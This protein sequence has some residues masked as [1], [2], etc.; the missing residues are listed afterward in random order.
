MT[1]YQEL[2]LNQS[3]SKNYIASFIKPKDKFVHTLIFIF[4]VLL[5]L[6]FCTAVVMGLGIVFGAENSI[7]GLV[8]LL[9]ILTFRFTDL[10]IHATHSVYG[11]SFIFLIFALGPKAA[12]LAPAGCDWLINFVC[13][14]LIVVVGCHNVNWYNHS[15]L[16]L[17]YLLL[18]GYDV[19]GVS[20]I[21]RL[22]CL[23]FGAILTSLVLYRNRRKTE[24]NYGFKNLFTD[25]KLS[26]GRS[27][28]QI[29]IAL[30]VSGA[31]FFSML[32]GFTKPIWAGIA[33]MSVTIPQGDIK[34]RVESRIRANV[35]AGIFFVI[36]LLIVPE[37]LISYLSMIGGVAAGF[38][39]RY[40]GQTAW[41]SFSALA[42][43]VASLGFY[44]AVAFRVLNNI[45]GALFA[46]MFGKIIDNLLIALNSVFIKLKNRKIKS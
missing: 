3:G 20:Y 38:C 23:S 17:S 30:C 44:T 46:F 25:F 8:V 27:R 13:I 4:K 26:D 31:V 45:F 16:I 41:N 33:A 39:A 11:I 2:Q 18:Y 7:A 10:D 35:I 34:T 43:S 32:I 21:N 36:A 29:K 1:F 12:N 5:N 28:W 24:F 37:G 42:V 9:G 22:G 40:E 15:I 14:L 19:S 6:A